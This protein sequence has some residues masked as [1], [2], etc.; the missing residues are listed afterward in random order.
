MH[1][2]VTI[3]IPFYNNQETILSAVKSVFAQSYTNWELM[4]LNDGSTDN[5]INLVNQIND[6]RVRIIND[7]INRGLVFRLNQIPILAKGIYL[8]RMDADDLMHPE[9]I[10]KQ[11]QLLLNNPE[12]DV[13][14]SGTYTINELG[15]PV[16]KR[17][18]D[19]I[20][21]DPNLFIGKAR[22][23]HASIL[24][25]KEWF[26]KNPYDPQYV[27]AEDCELWCRTYN[28]S[29]FA[30][31][32]EPLYIVREGKIK[33]S[34]YVIGIHT[35]RLI[36]KRYRYLIENKQRWLFEYIKTYCKEFL[37]RGMGLLG[38]HDLLTERRNLKLNHREV[39][40]LKNII[41]N[42]E[43]VNLP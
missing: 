4:L 19:V 27:R 3:A 2:L 39:V 10:Y 14:D 33:V 15:N 1:P 18:M 30:R 26:L 13:V 22:L 31:I 11:V 5:S 32:Q 9:R 25:K 7:T 40:V 36:L 37:Y 41:N 42:I 21:N 24:G 28:N 16:G 6:S 43:S 29:K 38:I 8:A 12:I 35:V 23:L 17:G 20:V 34:N